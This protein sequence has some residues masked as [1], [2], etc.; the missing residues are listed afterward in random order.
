MIKNK[1]WLRVWLLAS[2]SSADA[3]LILVGWVAELFVKSL[4]TKW[5][6]CSLICMSLPQC[7]YFFQVF[8]IYASG[9]RLHRASLWNMDSNGEKM[10]SSMEQRSSKPRT[11]ISGGAPVSSFCLV[12]P[13]FSA[14]SPGSCC[15]C[16]TNPTVAAGGAHFITLLISSV[17]GAPAERLWSRPLTSDNTATCIG[18]IAATELT[19]AATFTPAHNK[20]HATQTWYSI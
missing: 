1:A 4:V 5:N 6:T 17:G 15:W 13:L 18:T 12:R 14:L 10:R 11:A 9:A 8:Y 2:S 16:P 3:R 7:N 19:H 20:N